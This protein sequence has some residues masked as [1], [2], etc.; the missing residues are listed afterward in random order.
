MKYRSWW[1]TFILK[2]CVVSYRFI[3]PNNDVH[4]WNLQ[5][6][7]HNHWTMKYRSQ[8]HTFILRSNVG[9]YWFILQ[10]MIYIHQIVFKDIRQN[11]WT[12][13]YRS[14]WPSLHDPQV[15]V[16][17]VEHVRPTICISCLENRKVEKKTLKR[18]PRFWPL[19]LPWGMDPGVT[20]HGIKAD[21]PGYLW[22]KYECFLMSGWWDILHLR[23]FNVKLWSNSTNQTEVQTNEYTTNE[24]KYENYIPLDIKTILQ[25]FSFI[26]HTA[27]EELIF[28]YFFRKFCLLVAMVTNQIKRL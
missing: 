17:N 26:P 15:H 3:I 2:S 12:M 28:K 25:S 7:R 10:R 19:A 18:C 4:T 24:R 14:C 11:H 16:T 21:P 27:S 6:I 23:N 5:G 8:W 13:K 22:S 20:S 1:P 9:S